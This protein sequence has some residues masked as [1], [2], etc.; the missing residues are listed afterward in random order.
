MSIHEEIRLL[1]EQLLQ[2][3]FRRNR[4]AVAALLA[5]EFREFGSSGSV[6]NKQEILDKLETEARFDAVMEGFDAVELA[7]GVIL[8]TYN[9]LVGDRASLRSSIWMK[10][11]G[12]WQMLF[13]QGTMIRGWSDYLKSGAVASAGFMEGVED[14]PPEHEEWLSGRRPVTI[15][16]KE[17]AL[18]ILH[19]TGNGRS[20]EPG[21]ELPE[22]YKRASL[23]RRIR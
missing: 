1:E 16:D 14:P 11:D 12:R 19:R 4:A 17:E 6:W 13:H 22:G 9:V 3:D 7:P 18:R 23:K 8:A 5:D 2:T 20:P 21:D 10:R 15:A